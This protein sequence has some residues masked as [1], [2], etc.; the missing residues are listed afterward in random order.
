MPTKEKVVESRVLL[1]L[2][3]KARDLQ[4]M[5]KLYS[6]FDLKRFSFLLRY[7]N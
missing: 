4:K 7:L 2:G 3:R 5:N 6:K 1:L